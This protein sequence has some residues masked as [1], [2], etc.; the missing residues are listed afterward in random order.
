MLVTDLDGTLLDARQRLSEVNRDALEASSRAGV[1]RVVATGRSLYAARKVIDAGFPIDYLVYSSGAG[2]V[3]WPSGEA[4]HGQDM[5]P[6][7][8]LR[9]ARALVAAGL[10]FIDRQHAQ[11]HGANFRPRIRDRYRQ[12]L[13]HKLAGWVDQFGTSGCVGCGRC[14]TWCPVGIDLT[15]ETR[16]ICGA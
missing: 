7:D 14:I 2:T 1:L 15:E 12:W 10:D 6:A 13:V 9:A 16:A 3:S 11:V 5:G 4:F 8:C